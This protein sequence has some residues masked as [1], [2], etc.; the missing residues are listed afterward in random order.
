MFNYV[1]SNLLTEKTIIC[2]CLKIR[3]KDVVNCRQT[4]QDTQVEGNMRLG[5]KCEQNEGRRVVTR[6]S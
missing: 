6:L 5:K 4:G 3:T 2:K 1:A